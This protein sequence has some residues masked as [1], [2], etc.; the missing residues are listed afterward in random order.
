MSYQINDWFI[1]RPIEKIEDDLL[2]RGNFVKS[3]A[4]VIRNW[5]NKKDSLIISLNG[6]WGCGKSSLKNMIVEEVENVNKID[7][8]VNN[9]IVVHFNPWEWSGQGKLMDEFFQEI[10]NQLKENGFKNANLLNKFEDISQK[11]TNISEVVTFGRSL[12]NEI[13]SM[14]IGIIAIVALGVNLWW[15][16][17]F[18]VPVI[19]S[20][21]LIGFAL[22]IISNMLKLN[23]YQ[24]ETKIKKLSLHK[25]K[26]NIVKLL[27]Y[28]L[29]TNILV[30]IDDVDRLTKDEIKQLL[31]L[32]KANANLPNM[33]Y[34]LLFQYNIVEEAIKDFYPTDK[35]GQF[36]SKIIQQTYNVPMAE[37]CRLESI[38]IQEI[39]KILSVLQIA[40]DF[41][42]KRFD[43][44]WIESCQPYFKSLRD[45]KHYLAS[46]DTELQVH[47]NEGII[48]VNIFDII[49]LEVIK[50]FEHKVYEE[51]VNAK[52]EMAGSVL[53]NTNLPSY[54]EERKNIIEKILEKANNKKLIENILLELF[55]NTSGI[56]KDNN[57]RSIIFERN[58]YQENLRICKRNIYDRYFTLNIPIKQTSV[59]VINRI[60]K[61][62]TDCSLLSLEFKN[63]IDGGKFE[64]LISDINDF[65]NEIMKNDP[66][67]FIKSI[68]DTESEW[69]LNSKCEK[70][71][72]QNIID[73]IKRI[74]YKLPDSPS[75]TKLLKEVII[76]T[77]SLVVPILLIHQFPNNTVPNNG[78]SEIDLNEIKEL[79]LSCINNAVENKA[80][81]S[82]P[83]NHIVSILNA[84]R[85]LNHVDSQ[86]WAIVNIIDNVDKLISFLK[87]NYNLLPEHYSSMLNSFDMDEVNEIIPIK[88]IENR[89]RKINLD[90]INVDDKEMIEEFIKLC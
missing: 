44:I 89:L 90:E 4:K 38:V 71:I 58:P 65:I 48:E 76:K 1:D 63:A 82:L 56:I 86:T 32:I 50:L 40:K 16:K 9:T 72:G 28:E 10:G 11:L 46:L 87:I 37:E 57:N 75:R 25:I 52:D 7:K 30:V 22:S 27:K 20:L 15:D 64:F 24:T 47:I 66:T 13:Y 68:I 77:K 53:Y 21:I 45:V 49:L 69:L 42:Q 83:M 51:L 31:Q 59:N 6:E 88:E 5:K 8:E 29:H 14:I 67:S 34:L 73:L 78:F 39:N 3:I 43:I 62:S 61:N 18:V 74:L 60:I 26:E 55:P 41:E 33:V 36:L 17:K 85:K 2:N 84:W 19:I 80:L 12:F 23:A 70:Y 81:L 54:V 35:T 79:E